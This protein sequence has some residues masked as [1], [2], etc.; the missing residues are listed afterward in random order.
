MKTILVDTSHN[1]SI[2]YEL[3]TVMHRAVACAIDL[4]VMGAYLILISM[5]IVD[6]Q[7]SYYLFVLLIP[8]FYHLFCEVLFDGQSIGKKLMKIRVV[9]LEGRKPN[10]EDY[11]LRWIFRLIEVTM[12]LGILAAI[13]ISSTEKNQRIGDILA[14]TTVVKVVPENIVTL[15]TLK[16]LELKERNIQYP[17]ITRYTDKD[18]LLVKETLERLKTDP[19]EANRKFGLELAGR[20]AEEIDVKIEGSKAKFLENAL[21]DY[22][23]LTR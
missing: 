10:I 4:A 21:I 20:I 22:I 2:R 1:I 18:M 13:N 3:A 7:S 8:G 19:N 9:T 16:G 5:I 14:K 6:M 15:D 17:G 23:F 11:F 12:S